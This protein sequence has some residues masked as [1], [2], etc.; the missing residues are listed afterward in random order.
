MFVSAW[1]IHAAHRRRFLAL[2]AVFVPLGVLAAAI[3]AI[4]LDQTPFTDT[5]GVEGGDRY[6][7][8]V[9]ALQV[10]SGMTALIPGVLVAAAVAMSVD[11]LARGGS[12]GLDL[13][14]LGRRLVPVAGATLVILIVVAVLTTT[15]VGLVF[16]VAFLIWHGITTQ[17][18][19]IEGRP[20]RAGLRRSR[21]LVRHDTWRVFAI[22]AAATGIG[23][24]TGPVA[25]LAV[26][27][28]SSASLSAI[29]IVSSVV[30]AVVMPYV[31]IVLV[32]LF[33]DLRRQSRA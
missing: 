33:F 28:A 25:G 17:A 18:C 1:R 30:Y 16:A 2:G 13:R 9:A 23:L 8:G 5:R 21:Q 22:T 15:V 3:Q 7:A 20:A 26:L 27:F 24:A 31:S 19:V 4:V 14:E 11:G 6:I 12:G 29:D 10:G 32:L